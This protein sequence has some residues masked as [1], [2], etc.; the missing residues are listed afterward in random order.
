M[1]VRRTGTPQGRATEHEYLLGIRG[2]VLLDRTPYACLAGS[3]EFA[4]KF[5]TAPMNIGLKI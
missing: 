1:A 4:D 5:T 2:A 3:G